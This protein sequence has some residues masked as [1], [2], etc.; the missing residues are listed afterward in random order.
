METYS[1]ASPHISVKINNLLAL[2]QAF[3][4]DCKSISNQINLEL[5]II[6]IR[7]EHKEAMS[8]I[9]E[10]IAIITSVEL[11]K[12]YNDGLYLLQKH[13]EMHQELDNQAPTL[14]KVDKM[15]T[16]YLSKNDFKRLHVEGMKT[17]LK[18]RRDFLT[19]CW[20]SRSE[21][22]AQHLDY[23]KWQREINNIETWLTEKEEELSSQALGDSVEETE[24]LIRKHAELED[25]LQRENE[26]V[27]KICRLTKIESEMKHLKEKEESNRLKET[28]RQQQEEQ[29]AL[30]RR[31]T[32]RV[33]REKR[34][35]E[36]R[37][38]TQEIVY[39]I[40]AGTNKG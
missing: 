32:L 33:N 31:E 3:Q 17:S 15:C 22:Y 37:R 7:K 19:D 26:R 29:E 4:T 24:E 35:A 6:S 13:N 21:L 36:E 23:L 2:F 14:D 34:R 30:K 10:K 20:K 27:D 40:K 5:V 8:W 9:S 39:P 12:T 18:E 28:H 11:A 38:R 25:L 16:E 1:D